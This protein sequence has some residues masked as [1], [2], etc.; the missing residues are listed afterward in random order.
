MHTAHQ[1]DLGQLMH[2]LLT[3]PDAAAPTRPIPAANEHG[4]TMREI[5]KTLSRGPKLP[6]PV[7]WPL[8][9]GGLRTLEAVGVRTRLRSDSLISLL[10]QDPKPDFGPLREV[11]VEFRE[12]APWA[13]LAR[14][15][16]AAPQ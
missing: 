16:S 15:P 9:F 14:T 2:R 10:N 4:H 11:G 1:E 12:F 6:I 5:M 8:I 7:P 13:R 3:I